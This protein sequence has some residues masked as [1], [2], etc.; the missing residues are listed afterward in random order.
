MWQ[1]EF[2]PRH[3][4]HIIKMTLV[5]WIPVFMWAFSIHMLKMYIL[6]YKDDSKTKV[7]G[8]WT[9]DQICNLTKSLSVLVL[10]DWLLKDCSESE[11]IHGS[12]KKLLP[13][14]LD[15]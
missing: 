1:A 7:K 3:K 10:N 2:M 13:A 4:L 9:D 15:F 6:K 11:Y 5:S 12:W 14:L 8:W